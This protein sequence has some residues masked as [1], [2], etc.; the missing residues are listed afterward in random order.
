MFEKGTK[1]GHSNGGKQK[2]MNRNLAQEKGCPKYYKHKITLSQKKTENQ[3]TNL[4]T[5]YL[6]VTI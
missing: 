1:Q 2:A 3:N 6:H 4:E 5:S